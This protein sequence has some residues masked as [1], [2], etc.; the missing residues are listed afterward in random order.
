MAQPY[1]RIYKLSN[2]TA[3]KAR[4]AIGLVDTCLLQSMGGQHFSVRYKGENHKLSGNTDEAWEQF[5]D[6]LHFAYQ[7]TRAIGQQGMFALGARPQWSLKLPSF[8]GTNVIMA[9]TDLQGNALRLDTGLVY[10]HA[11]I[12]ARTPN[13][14]H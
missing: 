10:T 2:G 14:D 11:Q 13:K 1:H 7:D 9:I 5:L 3:T 8:V 12:K 6:H 4:R